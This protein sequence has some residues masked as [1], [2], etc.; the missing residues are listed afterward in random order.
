MHCIADLLSLPDMQLPLF[1]RQ[2]CSR[3]VLGLALS[4]SCL[5]LALALML[6][7][8]QHPS[9]PETT[10]WARSAATATRTRMIMATI[11]DM[12]VVISSRHSTIVTTILS[13]IVITIVVVIVRLVIMVE[14]L[15]LLITIVVLIVVSFEVSSTCA[16]RVRHNL[17]NACLAASSI[18]AYLNNHLYDCCIYTYHDGVDHNQYNLD[19][20]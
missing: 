9:I 6:C 1:L 13:I 5:E 14:L 17:Y 11:V 20:I 16:S 8:L 2:L 18:H 4:L 3:L 7:C 15:H 10:S 19:T 12:T